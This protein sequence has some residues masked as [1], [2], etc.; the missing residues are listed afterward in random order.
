MV[1]LD[2]RGSDSLHQSLGS[3]ALWSDVFRSDRPSHDAR[4][5][6]DLVSGDHR[7]RIWP[8][9]VF[10]GGRGNERSLLALRRPGLDVHFPDGISAFQQ[11]LAPEA[12]ANDGYQIFS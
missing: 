7:R 9:E 10:G 6:R 8:V 5:H 1:R 11:V 3:T 4:D 12:Q 2:S